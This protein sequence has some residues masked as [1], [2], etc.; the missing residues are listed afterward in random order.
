MVEHGIVAYDIGKMIGFQD[1]DRILDINGEPYKTL[2]ELSGATSYTL[3]GC[4]M[5]IN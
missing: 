3:T 5:S 4:L 2:G 1:G